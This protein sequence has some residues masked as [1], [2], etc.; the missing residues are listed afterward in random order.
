MITSFAYNNV[1]TAI[2]NLSSCFFF[3][4]G[5]NILIYAE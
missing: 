4:G 5:F 2:E 3:N 1:F